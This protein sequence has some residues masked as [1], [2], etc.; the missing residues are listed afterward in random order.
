MRAHPEVGRRLGRRDKGF[1]RAKR[2]RFCAE[3]PMP[4][5]NLSGSPG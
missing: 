2:K 4:G 3:A 5:D 1:C